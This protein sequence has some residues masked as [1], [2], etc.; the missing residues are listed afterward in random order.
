MRPVAISISKSIS[1]RIG[2]SASRGATYII[3][4][5]RSLRR[6]AAL[7]ATIAIALPAGQQVKGTHPEGAQSGR[8]LRDAQRA[9]RAIRR[10]TSFPD[11]R[12]GA[13]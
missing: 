1:R 4:A 11:R 13:A 10:V 3:H 9:F 7:G 5:A 8:E 2:A 12:G 6:G